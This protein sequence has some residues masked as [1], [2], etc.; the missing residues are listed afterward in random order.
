M[1]FSARNKELHAELV[2]IKRR[3]IEQAR[4][5]YQQSMRNGT[6]KV[7]MSARDANARAAE[8]GISF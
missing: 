4:E 7:S 8:L 6:I 5:A 1:Q 3:R 2:Q